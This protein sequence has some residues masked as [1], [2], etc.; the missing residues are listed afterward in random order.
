[1]YS[2]YVV[3]SIVEQLSKKK[4]PTVLC[5]RTADTQYLIRNMIPCGIFKTSSGGERLF[6]LLSHFGIVGRV[7][8]Q[9]AEAARQHHV[10]MRNGQIWADLGIF[11]A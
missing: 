2:F 9:Q 11:P 7:R 10:A 1:V 8:A 5:K 4:K 3:L 6:D